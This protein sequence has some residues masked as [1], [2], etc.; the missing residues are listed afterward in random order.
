MQSTPLRPRRR[1]GAVA[2]TAEVGTHGWITVCDRDRGS[3]SSIRNILSYLPA[4]LSFPFPRPNSE[5]QTPSPECGN[6]KIANSRMRVGYRE[7]RDD[8]M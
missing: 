2:A 7:V 3:S 1:L 6:S 5:L 8:G 4:Y